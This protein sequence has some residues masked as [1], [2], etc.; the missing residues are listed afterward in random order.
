MAGQYPV[1]ANLSM[2]NLAA[3]LTSKEQLSFFQLTG[4]TVDTTQTRNLAAF[5]NQA[6]PNVQLGSLAICSKGATSPGTKILSTTAYIS[7]TKT[8]IDVYRL[9]LS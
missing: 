9:P 5:D 1:D 4:L 6:N 8:D 2:V 7:G 3:T